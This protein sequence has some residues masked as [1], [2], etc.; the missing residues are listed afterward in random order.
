MKTAP[1]V[2]LVLVL[3]GLVAWFIVSTADTALEGLWTEATG[4]SRASAIH[5]TSAPRDMPEVSHIT[6]FQPP[7]RE[8]R[9][10][11]DIRAIA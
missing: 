1:L 8:D 3:A 9:A 6:F 10:A 4:L 11:P 5:K 7:R 2:F